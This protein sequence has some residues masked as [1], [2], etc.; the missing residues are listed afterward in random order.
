MKL[1]NIQISPLKYL[2]LTHQN[3]NF[4]PLKYLCDHNYNT[5]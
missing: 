1:G 4:S 2:F 3:Y 5:D